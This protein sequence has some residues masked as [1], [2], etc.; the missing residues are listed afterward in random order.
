[1][2]KATLAEQETIILYN[3]A[4]KEAEI[5]THDPVLI[6]K[7]NAEPDVAKLKRDNGFGGYTYTLP[8]KELFIR[9]KRHLTGEHLEQKREIIKRV[10][11]T[12]KR[13]EQFENDDKQR[14]DIPSKD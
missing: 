14:A 6:K 2:K 12:R 13:R 3:Q 4:D 7:L 8:K 9:L 1:M 11:M 10:N 5:Y